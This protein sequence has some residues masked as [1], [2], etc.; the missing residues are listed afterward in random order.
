PYRMIE[1]GSALV[2]YRP[3]HGAAAVRYAGRSRQGVSRNRRGGGRMATT[4]SA[5]RP[6]EDLSRG[7]SRP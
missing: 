5:P 7:G 2:A 4:G 1:R 6:V 3:Q